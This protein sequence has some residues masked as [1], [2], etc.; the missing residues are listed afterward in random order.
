MRLQVQK[1]R[2][3]LA[4]HIPKPFAEEARVKQGTVVDLS[5]AEGR[6]IAAP[7]HRRRFF[8]SRLLAGVTQDKLRGPGAVGSPANRLPIPGRPREIDC[9]TSQ[10][11]TA[12][13]GTGWRPILLTIQAVPGESRPAFEK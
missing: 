2:N 10:P 9:E 12:A 1:W 11:D 5:V 8:L 7:V 6:L 13:H 3:S 4:L